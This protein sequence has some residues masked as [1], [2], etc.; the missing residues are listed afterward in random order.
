MTNRQAVVVVPVYSE[1]L[2][3][4]ESFAF[5]RNV[6]I[7]SSFDFIVVSPAGLRLPDEVEQA[8]E[9]VTYFHPSYFRS[10]SSYSRLLLNPDFYQRFQ[11][12][13]FLLICQLD[14]V[15]L[16][17]QLAYW[18]DA[19]YDYIGA[20]WFPGFDEPISKEIIGVGN[21]GLSLRRID[22]A[23]AVLKSRSLFW[24]APAYSGLPV[25]AG[26]EYI[27]LL[28][29]LK[30]ISRFL[31]HL[32]Y[33]KLFRNWLNTRNANE[34]LFW[35]FFAQFFVE[36]YALP[37]YNEALRFAFEVQPSACYELN[38]HTMPFGLHAWARYD[39]AFAERLLDLASQ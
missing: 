13:R 4:D 39:R 37:P 35:S 36:A 33:V 3:S 26:L 19:G 25:A 29:V 9:Q 23:L 15:I 38:G 31:P 11:D 14:C 21:G 12:Y 1:S 17:N 28:R 16:E 10:A 30:S 8:C 34:D 27:A 7:L 18:C 32:P 22:K 20:P 24:K 5:S 2:T 6:R